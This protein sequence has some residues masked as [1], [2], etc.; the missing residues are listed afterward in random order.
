MARSTSIVTVCMNRREHLLEAAPRVAAWPH[1]REHLIVDWSSVEP[2]RR[3]ELPGDPRIRL[4]R[5]EGEAR[6][7]LSRAYNFGL[8]QASGDCLFKL[9]ADGWPEDLPDPDA[10]AVDGLVCCF[11]SGEDGRLGQF[12]I[13]RG[14]LQQV[15]GF[16]EYLW[17]YGFDD[18]DLKARLQGHAGAEIRLLPPTALGVIPHSV[19]Y[20]ASRAHRADVRPGPLEESHSHA[21]KRTT[22]MANRVM[23]ASCPWSHRRA[24]S[25]YRHDP[26]ADLWHLVPDSLPRPP[27][28]VRQELIRLRRQQFWSRFLLLP[29]AVVKELPVKLLPAERQGD[30]PVRW[31]HRLYWHTIRR[32]Y[33]WP[34]ALLA[35]LKGKR[36]LLRRRVG[37]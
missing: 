36:Q 2:L 12:L 27:E 25:R 21:L 31:W 34:L 32:A 5:V 37:G 10:L 20:R 7:N 26:L 13:D 33:G 16:N 18:K 17:G 24:P 8:Q 14:L 29:D 3:R 15:G 28:G 9:D 4:L 6:W 30:F 22:S 23:A 19:E 35:Q 1:H 11:G